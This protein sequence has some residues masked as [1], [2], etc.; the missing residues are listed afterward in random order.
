[1]CFIFL[2]IFMATEAVKAVEFLVVIQIFFPSLFFSY[3]SELE[4]L[5]FECYLF[6]KVFQGTILVFT[7]MD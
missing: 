6:F 5:N 1:M 7:W 3:M 4:F 2:L